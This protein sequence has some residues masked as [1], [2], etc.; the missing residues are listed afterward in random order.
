MKFR[1][2]HYSHYGRMCPIETPE[3]P[4]IG[5][6]TSLATFAKINQY[7]FIEAPLQKKVDKETG[8]VTDEIVYMTA[9]TEDEFVIAQANEPLDEEGRFIDKKVSARYR[10][11]IL[12]VP[13]S[14]IDYMDISPRQLVSVVTA[15]IPF[16]ENDDANRALMGSNMQCQAVPLF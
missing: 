4:N 6:I 5:L 1:D 14:R 12:E 2:I 8:R 7:G 10:D 15:C 3:G 16:L 11:E 9:D 13:G